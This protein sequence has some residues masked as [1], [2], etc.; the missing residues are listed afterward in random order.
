MWS[1]EPARAGLR[2]AAIAAALSVTAVAAEARA[3]RF[4]LVVGNNQGHGQ[5]VPLRYAES[6]AARMARLLVAVGGFEPEGTVLLRGRTAG[7]IRH[8]LAMLADN[9]ARRAGDDLV[10]F[11]YSGHADAESLHVGPESIPLADLKAQIVALGAMARV[12]VLDACQAG[13]LVRAK[14]GAPAPAFDVAPWESLPRGLAFLASSSESEVAQESDELGGSFFTHFFVHGL[15]G[16]ADRDRNGHVSLAEAYEFA[17]RHTLAATVTSPIGPQHP[18]FR[19]DLAGQQ[20]IA[21]TF[22]GKHGTGLGRIVFDRP[23]RYLVRYGDG[24]AAVTELV[25]SG[26]EQ[27]ALD[28]GRYEVVRRLE[29][30]LEIARVDL[31]A[32][33]SVAL[34]QARTREVAYG[35]VVRKGMGPRTRSYGLALLGGARSDL[36]S[37]GTAPTGVVVWRTDVR[38]LS[39]EAR[40]G[41]G[42]SERAGEIRSTETW[43]MFAAVAGLRALDLGRTTLG[44]GVEAG[45]SGLA[46]QIGAEPRRA[47]SNAAFV[48]PLAVLEVPLAKRF[49]LRVDAE[50][51]LYVLRASSGG[52]ASSAGT[53]TAVGLAVR[54][55]AGAGLYF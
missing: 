27:L 35:Q 14:G 28:P 25:S 2:A 54:I 4:A 49:F 48:G 31:A 9:L 24:G 53:R 10:L 8:S 40:A 19:F 36:L 33:Q 52:P 34:S 1:A 30:H 23:G 12:V 5:D 51:P 55:A 20:D 26:G 45:W 21:L 22:P 39:F 38:W 11:Y 13:S 16:A 41:G 44:L 32:S 47:L 3:A 17:S 15:R 46:Q 43:E 37:L 18:T 50:A 7:E 6:D 42:R 29:R